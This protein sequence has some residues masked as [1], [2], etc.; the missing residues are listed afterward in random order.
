MDDK[1]RLTERLLRQ[2]AEEIKQDL[3]IPEEVPPRLAELLR[4]L[5]ERRRL[6]E[7]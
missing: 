1:A 2:I 6:Q 4:D 5:E 3:P 7:R